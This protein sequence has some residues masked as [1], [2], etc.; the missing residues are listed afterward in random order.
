MIAKDEVASFAGC[1][2]VAQGYDILQAW[3]TRQAAGVL[4]QHD[5]AEQSQACGVHHATAYKDTC[6]QSACLPAAQ[7]S[8]AMLVPWRP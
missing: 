8:T 6:K 1:D 3:L 4:S 7:Q 2:S 5:K